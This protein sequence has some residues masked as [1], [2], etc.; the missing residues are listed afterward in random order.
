MRP[1]LPL[2]SDHLDRINDYVLGVNRG[3]AKETGNQIRKLEAA[4][5]VADDERRSDDFLDRIQQ[6]E[7]SNIY[8]LKW[9]TL[10]EQA[11]K[12]WEDHLE[13]IKQRNPDDKRIQS[14]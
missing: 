5:V 8:V 7:D 6:L 9:E 13:L 4:Y 10:I 1:G 14:L 11:I 2:D 3:L 12:Q